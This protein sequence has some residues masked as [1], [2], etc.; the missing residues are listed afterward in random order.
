VLVI[1]DQVFQGWEHVS[2]STR[3]MRSLCNVPSRP[4]TK[5]WS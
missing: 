1:D 4:R 5:A 3:A 2:Q